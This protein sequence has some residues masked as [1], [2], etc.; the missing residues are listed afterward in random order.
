V[1]L[2]RRIRLLGVRAGALT[3]EDELAELPDPVQEEPTGSLFD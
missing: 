1:S 2:D 3:P